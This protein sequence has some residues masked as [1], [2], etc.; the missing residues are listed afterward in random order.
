MLIALL[1]AV[2][3]VPAG[4]MFTCTPIRVWD[5][6]GPVWCREGPRIRL[7]GIAAREIDGSCRRGQPCPRASGIAARDALVRLLG[8]ARGRSG[9]GHILVT[10][11]RL[12]CRSTG[13]AKGDR[14]GAWC[15]A[16]GIGDLS[17]AMIA[18]GTVLR[19]QRYAA[20]HCR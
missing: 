5:G 9:T 20:G 17:C 12:H 16:P 7:G 19:W 3:T 11:P 15:S 8:G 2:A 1:L 18:T 4:Q 13:N 10:G 14:T 6:D